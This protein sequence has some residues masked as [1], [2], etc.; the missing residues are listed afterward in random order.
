MID[1]PVAV[2]RQ[3]SWLDAADFERNAL[4]Y[5][6]SPEIQGH[7]RSLH[8]HGFSVI[9]S[10]VNPEMCQNL[11]D[12]I[13]A[14]KRS[15]EGQLRVALD[16]M[17]RLPRV[18]NL[19]TKIHELLSLIGDARLL[20]TLDA[21]FSSEASVYTSLYFE[22]GTSQPIHRDIPYFWTCPGNQYLGVWVALEDSHEQNGALVGVPGGHRLD[23]EFR[24]TLADELGIA[25]GEI[26][27]VDPR[28]WEAYQSRIQAL[29]HGA[30]LTR[31]Q[32]C[33]KAGDI[34]VWHPLFPHG[35]GPVL[36]K[37]ATRHSMVFHVTP[38]GV[39]VYRANV[40][41]NPEKLVNPAQS[42]PYEVASNGRR[43]LETS[44]SVGHGEFSLDYE[45][46]QW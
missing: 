25:A 43:F 17:G 28:L 14:W 3:V 45:S 9:K 21:Y 24:V 10:G 46:L 19:H 30:D 1:Q 40:Y 35:G 36:D 4:F 23:D 44:F 42:R 12:R 7:L 33:V 2:Q 22:K 18:V 38:Y 16:T 29:I 5:N 37:Q 11:V 6:Q 20:R 34:V 8:Y 26:T 27:E 32:I 15:N 39:P 41:F 31:R 13:A